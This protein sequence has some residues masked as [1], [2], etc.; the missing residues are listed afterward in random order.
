MGHQCFQTFLKIWLQTL[1][2]IGLSW[3]QNIVIHTKECL[4]VFHQDIS[5]GIKQQYI[6]RPDVFFQLYSGTYNTRKS[7]MF[8]LF[9]GSICI[10]DQLYLEPNL[11][12]L[13]RGSFWGGRR[14]IP[15]PTP[16]LKLVRIMLE[17]S[18]LACTYT[19]IYGFRKY[20][21]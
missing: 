3:H 9:L 13:F 19:H 16:C 15:S 4:K 2:L 11:G 1:R 17:T 12:G 14:G 18:Y 21:F 8:F 5:H 20:T 7:R 6:Y 10:Y